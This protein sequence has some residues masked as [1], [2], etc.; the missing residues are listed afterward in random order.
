MDKILEFPSVILFDKKIFSCLS[1][2]SKTNLNNNTRRLFNKH[3][4]T[5]KKKQISVINSYNFW[6][7]KPV[8]TPHFVPLGSFILPNIYHYLISMRAVYVFFNPFQL[9]D[10]YSAIIKVKRFQAR[11]DLLALA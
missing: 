6:P 2:I 3:F 9:G 11:S 1:Y 7:T 4:I 5:R 10:A 8:S